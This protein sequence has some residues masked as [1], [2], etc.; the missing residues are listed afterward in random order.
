MSKFDEYK[1]R[2]LSSLRDLF[3]EYWNRP[4]DVFGERKI[5]DKLISRIEELESERNAEISALA[6]HWKKAVQGYNTLY[7]YEETG[8]V[9]PFGQSSIVPT[10]TITKVAVPLPPNNV[11]WRDLILWHT[12]ES[13][14]VRKWE[15][16]P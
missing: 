8:P 11:E 13:F 1:H 3:K 12:A 2:E 16:R 10:M 7:Y 15:R 9:I 14:L 6:E 4:P 5:P